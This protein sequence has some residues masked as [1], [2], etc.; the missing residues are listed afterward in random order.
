MD[1]VTRRRVL[2]TSTATLAAIAG[3]S[4][5]SDEGDGGD[6]GDET[7]VAMT[8]D[9]AFDPGTVEVAVGDTVVWENE[10]GGDHSVTASEDDIPDDADYFASGGFDGEEEARNAWPDGAIADGDTYEH[11]FQ[12]AGT[13]D[14][15]CVPHEGLDMVGTVEVG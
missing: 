1:R 14:Y 9:F 12:T 13:Y 8:G 15:F 6:G 4:A 7:T 5:P 10:G 3:C 11:T 2:A